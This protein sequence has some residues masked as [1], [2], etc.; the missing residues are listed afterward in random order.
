M[1]E[2]LFGHFTA[3]GTETFADGFGNGFVETEGTVQDFG[4]DVAGDV[5]AGGAETAGEEEDVGAGEG[6]ADGVGHAGRV[7][8][9]SGVAGNAVAEGEEL[10]GEVVD[11]GVG[12]EAEEEFGAGGDEFDVH[13]GLG[14]SVAGGGG[15]SLLWGRISAGRRRGR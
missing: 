6:G 4:D 2:I 3:T 8:A 9:D 15:V 7:V 11:V 13:C 1:D 14:G 12:D 10:A 5:V